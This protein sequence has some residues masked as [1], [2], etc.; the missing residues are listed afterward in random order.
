[1]IGIH[2][3][4]I[5]SIT[6]VDL[7]R[8]PRPLMPHR[9]DAAEVS[10]ASRIQP[11]RRLGRHPRRNRWTARSVLVRSQLAATH[12]LRERRSSARS[13][14]SERRRGHP[15]GERPTTANRPALWRSLRR[16]GGRRR[17]GASGKA[18]RQ[19]A[20]RKLTGY[21]SGSSL[22]RSRRHARWTH[23]ANRRTHDFLEPKTGS[24]ASTEDASP[25][26][27]YPR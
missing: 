10:A 8:K 25:P 24:V 1:M 18:S 9:S 27:R 19:P 7:N 26:R 13:G 11:G 16:C 4:E 3:G 2:R 14:V 17:P 23:A 20:Y 5:D 15:Q 6:W 21:E 12:G 22:G